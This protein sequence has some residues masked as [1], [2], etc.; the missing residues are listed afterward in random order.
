MLDLQ[1]F[2]DGKFPKTMSKGH[3][4]SIK[5]SLRSGLWCITA[6]SLWE[7]RTFYDGFTPA[8]HGDAVY[9]RLMP[10]RILGASFLGR[11][12][13]AVLIQI[14]GDTAVYALS[15]TL[16][17]FRYLNAN[18]FLL[19]QFITYPPDGVRYLDLGEVKDS[20]DPKI[21]AINQFKKH[22]GHI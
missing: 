7:F 5:K 21:Q 10:Y 17:E 16:P 19:Y 3:K 4:S 11:L 15:A 14:K 1:Q 9:E 6:I 20:T 18:H 13:A 8:P 2:A 22:W 12:V